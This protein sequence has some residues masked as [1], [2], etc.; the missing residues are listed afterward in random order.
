MATAKTRKALDELA[1]RF[2]RE[3]AGAKDYGANAKA[4]ACFRL[5]TCATLYGRIAG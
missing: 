2:S 4:I 5:K 1:E 3:S